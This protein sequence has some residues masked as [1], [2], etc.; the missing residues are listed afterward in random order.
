ML[1]GRLPVITPWKAASL[2]SLTVQ[3]RSGCLKWG[4]ARAWTCVCLASW[5]RLEIEDNGFLEW[6]MIQW[7]TDCMQTDVSSATAQATLHETKPNKNLQWR[8]VIGF[9]IIDIVSLMCQTVDE[10]HVKQDLQMSSKT[11]NH[12]LTSTFA[13]SVLPQGRLVCF[14]QLP[15]GGQMWVPVVV[16]LVS[17]F[18]WCLQVTPTT[19]VCMYCCWYSYEDKERVV[20][21]HLWNAISVFT[22]FCLCVC[23]CLWEMMGGSGRKV[24]C[25]SYTFRVQ[26]PKDKSDYYP[27]TITTK[28]HIPQ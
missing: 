2:P 18:T 25:H 3:S 13:L 27:I 9:F 10:F 26:L 24:V 28:Q 14:H 22:F 11:E 6:D 21:S 20:P 7:I 23:V 15:V 5:Q 19:C 4:E 12:T 1:N 8:E 16:V 17:S